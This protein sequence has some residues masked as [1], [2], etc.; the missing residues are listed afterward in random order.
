[1]REIRFSYINWYT[2]LKDIIK[3]IWVVILA[4][5]TGFLGVRAYF[6]FSYKPIYSS[7]A[8]ISVSGV[9]SGSG[10]YANLSKAITAASTF[11]E[12]FQSAYFKE[13]LSEITGYDVDGT[14]TATQIEE[15]NL[16]VMSYACDEPVES[17]SAL[18]AVIDNYNKITENQ[19]KDTAISILVDPVV[20]ASPS[21]PISYGFYDKLAFLI[22]AFL[23]LV[24]IFVSSYFRDTVKNES[25]VN[26]MLDAKLWNVVYHEVKNK[27]LKAKI[28]F[29]HS[30][31]PLLIT[32]V[33]IDYSFVET[34]RV[35]A[36]KLQYLM[37]AKKIKTLM[38]TSCGENEG[39][40]TV[41]VN[42]A[43]AMSALGKKTL[44]VDADLRKPA[45]FNFFK[46]EE[47]ENRPGLGAVLNG[48]ANV[49]ASLRR[50]AE[51][52]LFMICGKETYK[53]SSEMFSQR[54]FVKFMENLRDCFDL[55]II[56]TS[57]NSLVSDAEIIAQQVDAAFIVVRQD[58]APVPEIN[59]MIDSLNQSGVHVEGCIFN[60]VHVLGKKEHAEGFIDN[61][62]HSEN[63]DLED[64]E[65]T[66]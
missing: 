57:P 13:R 56:D 46:N 60:D 61:D 28:R 17:F 12:M 34:F 40:S 42:L 50:D 20:P 62:L 53:N 1:M 29:T 44:L 55:I 15:T 59:D 14:I 47:S 3:N 26:A 24:V 52:G 65:E 16:I 63:A 32:N 51:T 5:I 8:T 38:I 18:M 23:V 43:L 41:S 49:S 64:G 33:L 37:N 25:D 48:D 27:T 6:D 35:A 31:D 2:T 45:V 54:R 22:C 21:N 7:Q 10:S 9:N 39:K 19:F 11:Q 66:L 58:L 36:L 30:K 4:A